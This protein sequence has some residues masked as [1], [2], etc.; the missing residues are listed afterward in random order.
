MEAAM[1]PRHAPATAR[2][3]QPILDVLKQILPAR[4]TLL[5]VASGTGEHAAFIAPRLGEGILWQ[6]T[7][8]SLDA[9][10]DIDAHA[11][12]AG[13]PHIRPTLLLDASQPVWPIAYADAILCCNMIHI[14]PWAAA[15]GLM[16]GAA[17]ILPP[18]APLILYGP[19]KRHG[20]HTSP[21]NAEFDASLRERD[22]RWGVRCLDTELQ[23]LAS[24]HGFRPADVHPMPS[25]N[26]IVVFR[27]EPAETDA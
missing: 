16:S 10:A 21:S 22:R 14:A 20:A 15:E 3:R 23:P 12:R 18:R 1:P 17:R 13:W 4:G 2:N 6:P 8:A 27:R 24:R 26:L 11:A 7:D 19:Y 5:E 9:L 25:N